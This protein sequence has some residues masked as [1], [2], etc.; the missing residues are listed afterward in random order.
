MMTKPGGF[1]IIFLIYFH[2][3][4]KELEVTEM[5]EN[6]DQ[7]FGQPQGEQQVA[8]SQPQMDQQG[9]YNQQA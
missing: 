2:T 8:Y 1:G 9:M 4:G 3:Q 6:Q 7:Q 5:N